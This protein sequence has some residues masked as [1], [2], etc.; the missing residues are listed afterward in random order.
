MAEVYIN[1][2]FFDEKDAKIS[3]FDRGFLYGDGVFETL[4]SYG[5]KIFRLADHLERLSKGA[6]FLSI[7]FDPDEAEKALCQTL[8]RSRLNDAMLRLTLTRGQGTWGL[9]CPAEP[10]PT[11]VIFARPFTGYPGQK[12]GISIC[13]SETRKTPQESLDPSLKSLNFLN[14]ILARREAT[15]QGVQEAILLNKDGYLAEG[16]VSN[17]FWVSENVL[18]TP[19]LQTGILPGVTRKVVMELAD[20]E[21]IPCEEGF[22]N[23]QDLF[24][25]KEVFLTNTGFEIMPVQ[26]VD[27][28]SFLSSGPITA[29][30]MEAYHHLVSSCI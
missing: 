18:Y 4:R 15:F 9:K 10:N 21:N 12:D 14:N 3:V 26:R 25:A 7:P 19:A 22:Y 27:D 6:G 8:L 17:L 16:S 28:T 20:K 24:A 29:R 11:T 2:V 5:G 1:G 30:L 13:I 23:P